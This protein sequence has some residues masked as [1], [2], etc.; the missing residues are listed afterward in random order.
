MR[1]R[2]VLIIHD[3]PMIRK[4]V[5]RY[6]LSEMNDVNPVE[7]EN[8]D[9]G[10]ERI[11][12]NEVDLVICGCEMS[13][14]DGVSFHEKMRAESANRETPFL[15]ITSNNK[16]EHLQELCQRGIENFLIIPF[17]A[18]ELA[19]KVND[20][21]NPRGLRRHER[22]SVPGTRVVM[23]MGEIEI[24]AEVVN[25]SAGGFLCDLDNTD[26]LQALMTNP[27][28]TLHIPEE[29][30]GGTISAETQFIHLSMLT[31]KSAKEPGKLRVAWR[32]KGLTEDAETML[33]QAIRSAKSNFEMAMAD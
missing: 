9:L 29:C 5:K 11:C 12:E 31:W 17:T 4:V 24:E 7:V 6:M 20:L 3:S 23:H 26:H 14:L 18:G 1:R 16:D 33:K 21:C 8:A 13:K 2:Q 28:V 15:L 25:F 30:G 19:E 10:V 22:V 27:E 32:L